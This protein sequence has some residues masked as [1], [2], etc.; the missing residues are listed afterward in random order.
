MAEIA[1]PHKRFQFSIF[2]LGMNPFLVQKVTLA[3]REIDVIEHGEGNHVIKTAGQVKL[4]NVTLEK[5]YNSTFPERIM[6]AWIHSIQDEFTGGGLIPEMYK[7]A[8]QVQKLHPNMRT[9]IRTWNYIGAWPTKI[10]GI[11][12]DR[13]SS[14][15]TIESIELAVDQEAIV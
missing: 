15:N 9:P 1:N 12:L 10:N 5:L 13:V 14:E 4:G 3:D 7:K 6:W 2:L 11:E 8:F